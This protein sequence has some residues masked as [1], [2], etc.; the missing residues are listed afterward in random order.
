MH[1]VNRDPAHAP[2][3]HL[4][5]TRAIKID[6]V[7]AS[8]IPAVIINDIGLA[9]GFDHELGSDRPPRPI[10]RGAS[11]GARLQRGSRCAGVRVL[12]MITLMIVV[13]GRPDLH[14]LAP[15]QRSLVGWEL[16]LCAAAEEEK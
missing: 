13:R 9:R 7:S 15:C 10:S 1:N 12:Q 5:S 3:V 2:C 16:T 8:Q 6:C 14:I 4:C 11:D